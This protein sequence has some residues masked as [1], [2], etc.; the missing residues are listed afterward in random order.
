M[1]FDEL[2][3]LILLCWHISAAMFCKCCTLLLAKRYK[4]FQ[5]DRED[6]DE[7]ERLGGP[8]PSTTDNN[9]NQS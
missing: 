2:F 6:V 3:Q 5:H 9:T 7:D 4:R 8:N 1:K